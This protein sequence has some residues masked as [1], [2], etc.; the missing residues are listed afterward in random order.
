M[1]SELLIN[2]CSQLG[3]YDSDD[4]GGLWDD[5]EED[6]SEEEG[7]GGDDDGA[8]SWE[9][10]SEHSVE[11]EGGEGGDDAPEDPAA[12]R[13]KV[14]DIVE[15]ACEGVT[16]LEEIF[17]DGGAHAQ[18]GGAPASGGSGPGSGGGG[19]AGGAGRGGT[20]AAAAACSGLVMKQ[21]LEVYRE[22]RHLDRLAGTSHF[23]EG[24]FEGLLE[25]VKDRSR[26]SSTQKM[27]SDQVNML[28]AEGER[29]AWNHT[30]LS[31]FAIGVIFFS[32]FF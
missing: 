26:I 27:V 17:R 21:F 20:S 32:F 18:Q 1:A 25:R 2:F 5:E 9:T 6:W 10:E 7:E 3:E 15:K 30:F 31:S 14:A 24:N 23:H 13:A 4:E 28:F 22:C 11:A 12:M 29:G 16:R 19:G 8:S